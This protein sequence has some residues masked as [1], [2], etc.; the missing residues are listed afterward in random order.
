MKDKLIAIIP[1]RGGSK[2]IPKKNIKDFMGKPMVAYAIDAALKSDLFDEVMVSTDSAE[3]AEVAKKYGAKV[4]FMRS[5]KTSNDYAVTFDV[6]DEV[7]NEYKKIGKTFDILCCI[8]PCVPFL[9]AETLKIAYSHLK[10]ND[11]LMPVCKYPVPIEW[12]MKIENEILIPNNR[13]AQNMRSQD[14]ELKYFDAGMFYFCKTD[15][16]YQHNSLIPDKTRAFI[17]DEK[18]CQDIDTLEDWETA[19]M[20]YKLLNNL[21]CKNFML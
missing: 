6:M 9:K 20:K 2:R 21:F 16:L 18:E 17:I 13:D 12:A 7:L 5:K 15:K 11:A 3:I 10:N 1:A 19:E 8:Y 14:I 4:P